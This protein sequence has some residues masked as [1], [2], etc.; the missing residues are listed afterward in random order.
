MSWKEKAVLSPYLL[1][2]KWLDGIWDD[3]KQALLH[4]KKILCYINFSGSF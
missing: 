2:V 3:R 4:F 1:G